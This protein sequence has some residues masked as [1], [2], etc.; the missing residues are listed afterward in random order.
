MPI[1]ELVLE[2]LK[3]ILGTMAWPA[4]VVIILVIY[5]DQISHLL[6]RLRRARLPG[7]TDFDFTAE[8]LAERAA[9]ET[10]EFSR[11]A[12]VAPAGSAILD[13]IEEDP[14]L[15]LA[16]LRIELEKVVRAIYELSFEPSDAR[17]QIGLGSMIRRLESAGHLPV[18]VTGYI[19]DVL[20]LANRAVH[21]EKVSREAAEDLGGLGVRLLEVLRDIYKGKVTEP[22]KTLEI[23]DTY[24]N[25]LQAS[26]YRVT[27]VVPLVDAPYLN[28]RT[29]SQEG[30]DNLLE[31]YEEY[32]EFLVAIEPVDASLPEDILS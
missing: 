16:Q 7:G 8:Q 30:L 21:G 12:T 31:G 22:T 20:T 18:H 1:R 32:G 14:E 24:R 28:V 19:T 25:E 3:T 26:Q 10:P 15:G 17:R 6:E 2:Y 4:V 23:T 5:R 9:L 29:L 11:Q 13:R 27:T